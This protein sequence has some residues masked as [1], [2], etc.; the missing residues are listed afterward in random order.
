[1]GIAWDQSTLRAIGAAGSFGVT[2]QEIAMPSDLEPLDAQ[3]DSKSIEADEKIL[4]HFGTTNPDF[5]FISGGSRRI[6]VDPSDKRARM[7]LLRHGEKY[8]S[9]MQTV[10]YGLHT[11][12]KPDF[13]LDVGVNYGECLF[14]APEGSA[15]R[16]IG[17]E[18]NPNLVTF[19]DRSL[20]ENPDLDI[21][22]I[23]R[24]VSD[25]PEGS[26]AFFINKAWSGKST[27][28]APT[29]ADAAH[30]ERIEV[31]TTTIDQELRETI[32]DGSVVVAKVDVE[33]LEPKVLAGAEELIR[34]CRTIVFCIEFDSKFLSGPGAAEAFFNDLARLFRIYTIRR[35]GIEIVR[36][37][38]GLVER[39]G[40]S[41]HV[42]CD[43]MLYRTRDVDE[44]NA[45]E[46]RFCTKAV[47]R[48][49]HD[50][51]PVLATRR[52]A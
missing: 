22:V 19:L 48:M 6:S 38:K 45:F 8:Y 31:P 11:H 52:S 26:L 23:Q 9:K 13:F 47:V 16:I 27:A 40:S 2:Q 34:R 29:D 37:Y 30:I 1:L 28:V 39:S 20:A 49:A 43:L 42:H 35:E 33:G 7:Q 25:R 46:N 50:F 5:A 24:A 17:F 36:D 3:K 12:L 4:K 14:S 32:P 10:V 18:A 51:W 15:T 21:K 44:L 41:R